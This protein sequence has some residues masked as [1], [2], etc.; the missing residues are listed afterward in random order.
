VT[1]TRAPKPLP[2]SLPTSAPVPTPT[3]TS[4]PAPVPDASSVPGELEGTWRSLDQ[5]SAEV[6]YTFRP[7]GRS[8]GRRS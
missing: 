5:G 1:V 8:S 7:D 3:P 6:L 4:S 2:T